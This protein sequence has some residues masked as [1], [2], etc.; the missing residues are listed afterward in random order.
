MGE[1]DSG[2]RSGNNDSRDKGCIH[3]LGREKKARELFV[4]E[5]FAPLPPP[6]SDLFQVSVRRHA[7]PF[8]VS[9][10][11]GAPFGFCKG[12]GC[13]PSSGLSSSDFELRPG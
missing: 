2:P 10:S 6:L 4:L 8:E 13:L 7:N 9:R 1:E 12:F 3:G 5:A 11:C